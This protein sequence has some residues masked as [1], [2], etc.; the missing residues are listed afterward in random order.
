MSSLSLS[1]R[2]MLPSRNKAMKVFSE[3]G[4]H[5]IC[6]TDEAEMAPCTRQRGIEARTCLLIRMY[7]WEKHSNQMISP[8]E[9]PMMT[10]IWSFVRVN[11]FIS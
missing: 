5:R 11:E 2:T 7:F 10:S 6:C 1:M 4:T 3:R 8:V 9:N